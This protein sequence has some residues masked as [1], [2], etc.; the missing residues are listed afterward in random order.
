M[1]PAP[2]KDKDLG[3]SFNTLY[4]PVPHQIFRQLHWCGRSLTPPS[5]SLHLKNPRVNIQK[6]MENHQFI[7]A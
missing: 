2:A 6:T 7:A 5:S 3:R 4:C 1:G